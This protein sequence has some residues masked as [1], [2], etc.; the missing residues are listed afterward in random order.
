MND[1]KKN[2]KFLLI[3]LTI[4]A[5]VVTFLFAMYIRGVN[6]ESTV[7]CPLMKN[8]SLLKKTEK[9]E[10]TFSSAR[11]ISNRGVHALTRHVKWIDENNLGVPL[12]LNSDAKA[13]VTCE[14]QNKSP[15]PECY[16]YEYDYC[17][18]DPFLSQEDNLPCEVRAIAACA[19]DGVEYKY[20]CDRGGGKKGEKYTGGSD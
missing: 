14:M 5:I 1:R 11:D 16:D 10:K 6:I 7:G 12:V 9:Q 3:M 18:V 20:K 2:K 4:F 13:L 15:F 19:I 17:T 8:N